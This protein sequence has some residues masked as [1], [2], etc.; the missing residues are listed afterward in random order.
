MRARRTR[1]D[2]ASLIQQ[3]EATGESPRA[4]CAKRRIRLKTFE[5]WRW[6]LRRGGALEQKRSSRKP[7]SAKSPR[8]V[9]LMPV[10]V[11]GLTEATPTH[12]ELSVRD[13]AVRLE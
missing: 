13:V 12:I 6:Q 3:I 11:A 8:P 7:A 2:W 5:W 10:V 4:F 9:R 1:P